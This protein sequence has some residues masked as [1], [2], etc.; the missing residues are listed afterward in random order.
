[1][2]TP[3]GLKPYLFGRWNVGAEA[4]TPMEL[5]VWADWSRLYVRTMA[6]QMAG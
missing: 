6:G 5:E 2:S 1:M 4:P 3:Q